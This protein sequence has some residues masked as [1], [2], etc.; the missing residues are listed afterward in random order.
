VVSKALSGWR[1][2]TL[3]GLFFTV[4]GIVPQAS[5]VGFRARVR[6]LMG[7]RLAGHRGGHGDRLFGSYG[8]RMLLRRGRRWRPRA[9]ARFDPGVDLV[10]APSDSIVADHKAARES[11][12]GFEP[13]D[14]DP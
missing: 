12:R 13:T 5:P 7:R 11:S 1:G 14:V 4:P 9:L 8:F 6:V 10:R 3:A 2:R